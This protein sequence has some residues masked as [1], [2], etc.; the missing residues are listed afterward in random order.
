M[1]GEGG[2]GGVA[3]RHESRSGEVDRGHTTFGL[4]GQVKE[5]RLYSVCGVVGGRQKLW[6][7]ACLDL[8]AVLQACV[9][10]HGEAELMRANTKGGKAPTEETH[11][12]VLD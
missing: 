4:S 3:A 1:A 5:V 8:T 12:S 2:G 9:G 6:N 7:R 10:S 11:D